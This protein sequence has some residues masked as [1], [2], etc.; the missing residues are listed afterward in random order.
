[1]LLAAKLEQPMSPS[2][3]RMIN[4]LPEGV[5]ETVTKEKLVALEERIIKELGF[6]MHHAGPIPYLQ[7]FARYFNIDIEKGCP[8]AKQVGFAARQFCRFMMRKP[9]FLNYKAS[10][11]AAA[12]FLLALNLATSGSATKL[13]LVQL[14]RDQFSHIEIG[15]EAPFQFW[16]KPVQQ[17]ALISHN[18]I[19]EVYKALL[20]YVNE[21]FFKG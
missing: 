18:E 1:M 20:V 7:R 9:E 2:F 6:L 13:G 4:L 17:L 11:Q 19:R 16:S 3:L 15:N 14:S 12:A 10:Q 5:R 21:L 8:G